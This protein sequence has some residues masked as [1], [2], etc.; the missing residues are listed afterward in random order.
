MSLSVSPPFWDLNC[1]QC[2]HLGLHDIPSG[3]ALWMF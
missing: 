3:V 2:S 1:C